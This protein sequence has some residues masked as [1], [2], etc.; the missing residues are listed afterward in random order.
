LKLIG[1]K[2][3]GK[4]KKSMNK[5]FLSCLK[6]TELIEKKLHFKLSLW[7]NI[8]LKMHKLMCD[9]CTLYEKQ[10]KTIDKALKQ[11]LKKDEDAVDLKNLK[12]D[13]ISRIEKSEQ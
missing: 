8:R 6:A 3:R 2:Y 13:I 12:K 10:S 4:M 1:L 11:S 9:A 5:L 7:E